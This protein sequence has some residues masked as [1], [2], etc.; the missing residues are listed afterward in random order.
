MTMTM[1]VLSPA[2]VRQFETDGYIILSGLLGDD[3]VEGLVAA[4]EALVEQRPPGPWATFSLVEKGCIFPAPT[5]PSAT[6][7]FRDVAL[8][9]KLAAVSAELMQ[10]DPET[11]N[12]RIL[13]YVGRYGPADRLHYAVLTSVLLLHVLHLQRRFPGKAGPRH[14]GLRLAR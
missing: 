4:G 5:S 9:S 1:R 11:Q 7:E 13:R 14:Y 2:Q 8:R 12:C 3:Q 6:N 10:L